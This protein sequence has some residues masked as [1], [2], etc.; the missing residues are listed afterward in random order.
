MATLNLTIA[1]M[2]SKYDINVDQ[3]ITVYQLREKIMHNFYGIFVPCYVQLSL[4][5]NKYSTLIHPRDNNKTLAELKIPNYSKINAISA[6]P[7]CNCNTWEQGKSKTHTCDIDD[8]KCKYGIR[9]C[10]CPNGS[11]G[12]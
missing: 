12:L 8:Q 3:S 6:K 7:G 1:T 5:D 2:F 4:C 10:T 11:K 9:F